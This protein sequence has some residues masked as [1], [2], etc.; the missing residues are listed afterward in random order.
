VRE[1][2]RRSRRDDLKTLLNKSINQTLSRTVLTG[3]SVLLVLT[4]LYFFGGN[5]IRGFAFVL[6]VGVIVGTYGT[7]FVAS[8]LVL[9][10]EGWFGRYRRQSVAPPASERPDSASGSAPGSRQAK[11]RA[12]ARL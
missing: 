12:V 6:L 3:G 4:S 9:L 2:L 8:P 10:W 5:V 7:I 1:N 11:P